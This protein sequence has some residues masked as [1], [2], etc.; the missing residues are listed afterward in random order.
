MEAILLV[1]EDLE[2]QRQRD[3]DQVKAEQHEQHGRP[4]HA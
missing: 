1:L 4:E 2:L 3:L